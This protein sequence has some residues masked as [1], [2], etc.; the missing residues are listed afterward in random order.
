[1]R[2]DG[3]EVSFLRYNLLLQELPARRRHTCLTGLPE[4]CWS[5][6][7]SHCP[8]LPGV[9]LLQT[10]VNDKE[11]GMIGK[12]HA[13]M[14]RQD[15]ELLPIL[16]QSRCQA[17]CLRWWHV[18]QDAMLLRDSPQRPAS[19]PLLGVAADYAMTR[20]GSLVLT[21]RESTG[22]AKCFANFR[23]PAGVDGADS[24]KNEQANLVLL[25]HGRGELLKIVERVTT[26][27]RI[28]RAIRTLREI[29]L[30]CQHAV[31][32]RPRRLTQRLLPRHSLPERE[33]RWQ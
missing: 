14:L 26:G 10:G 24:R 20:D 33:R 5:P 17:I 13:S 22:V 25:N 15:P 31:L 6:Y 27:R 19:K 32:I 9:P 11:P 30:T 23:V 3:Y 21:H 12:R 4:L 18:G 7:I 29:D 1:M 2:S 28:R 8:I 16:W